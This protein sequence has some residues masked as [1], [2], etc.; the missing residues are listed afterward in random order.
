MD[1]SRQQNNRYQRMNT[2]SGYQQ[3][4]NY[5]SEMRMNYDCNKECSMGCNQYMSEKMST[6]DC[7][8]MVRD[9]LAGLSIG[10]GYVPWQRFGNLYEECEGVYHGT[11]FQELD[12]DF[13]G[14][15]CE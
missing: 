14:M 4:A 7:P 10:I 15:R 8:S 3:R 11:I 9:P 1:R 12:L 5:G 6:E 2:R 13:C